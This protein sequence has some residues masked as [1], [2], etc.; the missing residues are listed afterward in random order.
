MKATA[1]CL[2]L[3]QQPIV[4]VTIGGI[5]AN[6]TAQRINQ[7]NHHQ[8]SVLCQTRALLITDTALGMKATALC[9]IPGQQSI[10]LVTIGGIL[11]S[12]TAPAPVHCRAAPLIMESASDS[13]VMRARTMVRRFTANQDIGGTIANTTAVHVRTPLEQAVARP[14]AALRTVSV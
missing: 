9:L 3:G 11:V 7:D 14:P 6:T 8:D 10:V 12:M 2:I 13:R 5:L 1:L 4:L